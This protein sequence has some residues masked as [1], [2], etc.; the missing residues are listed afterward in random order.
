MLFGRELQDTGTMKKD[1][2]AC[3]LENLQVMLTACTCQHCLL[4]LISQRHG[5]W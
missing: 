1:K 2:I 3:D 4:L 5:T